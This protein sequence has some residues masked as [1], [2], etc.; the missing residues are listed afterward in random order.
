MKKGIGIILL[1]LL[2]VKEQN[3]VREIREVDSFNCFAKCDLT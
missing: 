3:F 1:A 2:N